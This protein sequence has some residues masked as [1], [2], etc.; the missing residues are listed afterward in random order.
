MS[1]NISIELLRSFVAV[2]DAGSMSKAAAQI[3]VTQSGL[4]LQMKRL[5]DLLQSPIFS[6]HSQGM[7]LTSAGETLLE[8]GRAAI[9]LNDRAVAA[10]KNGANEAPIR[11]GLS[12]DFAGS[13]LSD[14]L[15]KIMH[16]RPELAFLMRVGTAP[17]LLG[18]LS[19]GFLDLVLVISESEDPSAVMSAPM[20][21]F[22]DGDI[23][24]RKQIPIAL[25]TSPCI[26]RDTALASLE[27]SDV[28]YRIVLETHSVLVLRAA[29]V[30]GFAATCRTQSL[31][32]SNVPVLN[33]L[34]L[35]LPHVSYCIQT[36]SNAHPYVDRMAQALRKELLATRIPEGSPN[37]LE[38]QRN[39]SRCNVGDRPQRA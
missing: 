36:R 35:S 13:V 2:V 17:D 34:N 25:M 7:L 24:R 10:I 11:V 4:S 31:F 32:G 28:S 18:Q 5:A 27:A 15:N 26:F 6:R 29:I 16:A 20:E 23:L 38:P 9:D 3:G 30:G 21:W 14:T 37:M 22:G 19:A 33:S 12:Q 39:G 1:V 8:Y